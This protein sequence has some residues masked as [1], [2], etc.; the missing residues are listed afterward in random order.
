MLTAKIV[1]ALEEA[2]RLYPDNRVN[3]NETTAS[4][5]RR[6]EI[7]VRELQR[8]VSRDSDLVRELG[9]EP[10]NLHDMD[11]EPIDAYVFVL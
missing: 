11:G 1:D 9:F 4:R 10:A 5:L 6:A 8:E 7:I 3:R 2:E